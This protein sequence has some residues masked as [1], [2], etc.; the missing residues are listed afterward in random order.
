MNL[1]NPWIDLPQVPP[2]VL[3]IDKPSILNFNLRA[4]PDKQYD[5]SLLPE[6]F[7]GSRSARIVLLALN[8]GWS[9]EDA[10]V[11]ADATFSSLARRSLV[12]GLDEYPFLH[13][14]PTMSTPGA[15][16]WKRITKPLIDVL[17]FDKVAKGISCL[18]LFPYHS[19][20]FGSPKLSL[21]S[22]RF[23]FDLLAG[24]IECG[25]EIVVMRSWNLW[26][27]HVT[28]LDG[29]RRLHRTRNPRN[30]VL[31]SRNLNGSFHALVARLESDA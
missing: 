21:P 7:F 5:L 14:R 3:P 10:A 18:Q 11:H 23:V 12:Y 13:L 4:S 9:R 19:P 17:G 15:K 28:Q 6:P 27:S 30:P 8:P 22:Q 26:V 25:A 16:W 31:S 20:T 2:Y 1:R 24:A 29:Y